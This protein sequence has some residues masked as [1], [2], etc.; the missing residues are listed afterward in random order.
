MLNAFFKTASALQQAYFWKIAGICA[1][2]TLGLFTA[3][4]FGASYALSTWDIWGISWLTDAT[5]F[6]GGSA[7]IILSF[8]LAP[9]VFPLIASFFLDTVIDNVEKDRGLKIPSQPASTM[10]ALGAAIKFTVI[11]LIINLAA[12]PLFFIPGIYYLVNGY[13]FG[14]E[15][16]EMIALRYHSQK[17]AKALRRSRKYAVIVAGIVIAVTFT[18]PIINLVAP[19]LATI[20]MVHMYHE[21]LD[22]PEL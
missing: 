8:I 14:R 13:L 15:Y 12:L 7:A 3:M 16:F 9:L 1:A 10:K 6:L 5:A 19:I 11:A 18:I 4:F 2:I 17:D 22:N 21:Q 20:F